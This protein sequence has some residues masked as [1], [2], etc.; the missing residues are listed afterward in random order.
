[1]NTGATDEPRQQLNAEIPLRLH[2]Q[3]KSRASA[4]R[5]PIYKAVEEAMKIW[6][7]TKGESVE[8]PESREDVMIQCL[9]YVMRSTDP[10][11]GVILEVVENILGGYEDK[12]RESTSG[13]L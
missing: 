13:G 6:L 12:V 7:E 3:F 11:D 8:M 4:E 9:R 5:M 1:M 10:R 2:T